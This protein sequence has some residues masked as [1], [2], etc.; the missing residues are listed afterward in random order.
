MNVDSKWMTKYST[1]RDN[2]FRNSIRAR[3]DAFL[4]PLVG[5]QQTEG[6]CG[7]KVNRNDW[8]VAVPRSLILR[9][10]PS[11]KTAAKVVRFFEENGL[12][13][14]DR[15]YIAPGLAAECGLDPRCQMWH[16]TVPRVSKNLVE[17]T[18]DKSIDVFAHLRKAI[19]EADGKMVDDAH[20]FCGKWAIEE[21]EKGKLSASDFY[22]VGR[23]ALAVLR[24]PKT[25]FFRVFDAVANCKKSVR[26]KCFVDV[27]S[28][29]EMVEKYDLSAAAIHNAPL[30]AALVGFEA[31]D[32]IGYNHFRYADGSLKAWADDQR[33]DV[34]PYKQIF[35]AILAR[36]PNTNIFGVSR[37]WTK[38]ARKAVKHAVNV[39]F[40][41]KLSDMEEMHKVSQ[42]FFIEARRKIRTTRN[43]MLIQRT[44]RLNCLVWEAIREVFPSAWY[45]SMAAKMNGQ[46]DGFYLVHTLA[47]KMKMDTIQAY[48]KAHH[49]ITLHRVHDALWTADPRAKAMS[50]KQIK[51]DIA[52][53]FTSIANQGPAY[54]RAGIRRLAKYAGITDADLDLVRDALRLSGE[55]AQEFARICSDPNDYGYSVGV[56][57]RTVKIA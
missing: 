40:N 2:N 27:H 15:S 36:Y 16:F 52:D 48:Y 9:L 44:A 7:H 51:N 45:V 41:S 35:D 46:R 38:S 30:A 50:D 22:E 14:K 32:K 57:D 31:S 28:S 20:K 56:N 47:E 6:I 33:N 53:L 3:L 21:F 12:I 25:K 55:T 11:K 26:G 24:G 42:Y 17:V 39:V 23:A 8:S 49:G 34:D 18:W 19:E 13:V 5:V 37:N 1:A 4:W 43:K 54:G 29:G 10:F